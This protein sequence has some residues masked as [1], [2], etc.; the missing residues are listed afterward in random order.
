VNDSCYIANIWSQSGGS[1]AVYV[2]SDGK[3]GFQVSSRR[4]KDHIKPMEQAS[5]VI[6]RLKPVSFHYKPEIERT[7]PIGFGLIA[8]DVGKI[9]S[10]LVTRGDD[11]QVNSVRW[12][13][14]N[15]MLLNEFLK[16]HKAFTEQ[17]HKMQEL[18]ETV[19]NLMARVKEQA[20]RIQKVSAQV[21]ARGAA[22]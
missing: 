5:E 22:L 10:D 7:Q 12:D 11:G 21:D 20:V 17:K 1:Q 4:F 14:V 2:S 3:L 9:S 15:A 8:E 18:E 19:A 16:E 6:Y 13:Q